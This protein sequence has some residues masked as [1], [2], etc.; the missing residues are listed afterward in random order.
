MG[1][2]KYSLL[3][4]VLENVVANIFQVHYTLTE[5]TGSLLVTAGQKQEEKKNFLSIQVDDMN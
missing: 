2:A 1:N 5:L 4:I 3:I